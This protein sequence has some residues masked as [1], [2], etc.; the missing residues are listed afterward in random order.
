[1]KGFFINDT[2]VPF[3]SLIL[4]LGKPYET[5]NVRSLH[6]VMNE[7]IA[8]I[9]TRK[10]YAPIVVGYVTISNCIECHDENEFRKYSAKCFVDGTEFDW[11]KNTKH[12]Y[13][14]EMSNP[15]RCDPY[16]VPENAVRHG[17]VWCEW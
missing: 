13:L 1:M 7:R 17:R 5:R 9:R 2:K 14:Y 11:N 15:V 12:K 3:T 6:R 4:S 10:G 8:I 16:R